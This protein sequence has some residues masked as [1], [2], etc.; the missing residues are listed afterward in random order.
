MFT[1]PSEQTNPRHSVSTHKTHLISI[2]V[3][4]PSHTRGRYLTALVTGILALLTS[5]ISQAESPTQH[6]LNIVVPAEKDAHVRDFDTYF[7]R[8][9][10][11]ALDK[12]GQ[13]YRITHKA[14]QVF[15]EA[16]SEHNLTLNNYNLHWL[17]TSIERESSLIPVKVPLFKGL[18]GWRLLLIRPE[19][20]AR[21]D[22]V[23]Q[24]D[25]LRPLRAGQGH[26]WP[27]TPVLKANGLTV[28]AS[29]SWE[30]LFKMLQLDRVDYL[31]RS[32]I[33]IWREQRIHAELGLQ[34]ESH[35]A[36]NYQAAYYFFVNKQNPQI[37]S[38]VNRGL[39]LAVEDGSFDE[40]FQQYFGEYLTKAQLEKRQILRLSNPYFAELPDP[41]LWYQPRPLQAPAA[42][43]GAATPP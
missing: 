32:V 5:Q 10:E 18:I 15:N 14:T 8:L 4:I 19:T 1:Q 23:E 24:L 2:A 17:N 26:D 39:L 38:A 31:P 41:R 42:D 16:R 33:E 30:G 20:Q 35:L 34:I 3:S 7:M 21:F 28:V 40:V 43:L 9:L 25:Q 22:K 36:L 11:L 12:S 37:A 13:P 6:E 27:D 29:G